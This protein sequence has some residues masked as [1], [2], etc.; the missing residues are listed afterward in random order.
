MSFE[1]AVMQPGD[2]DAA[3]RVLVDAFTRREPLGQAARIAAPD[4]DALLRVL[5][6]K[7]VP[8]QLTIVARNTAGEIV[9]VMLNEDSGTPPPDGLDTLSRS[10]VPIWDFLHELEVEHRAGG[11]EPRPGEW[12]HLFLLAVAEEVCGRGV[13][14][15]M[16][17]KSLENAKGRGY[18]TAVVEATGPASQNIFRKLGFT[19]RVRRPYAGHPIFGTV[20]HAGGTVLM[21]RTLTA[22]PPS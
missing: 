21:E 14:Q 11:R 4:F 16:V 3:P 22:G 15:G 9:G 12:L 10:F 19:D 20:A 1:Y 7:I 13:A 18:S 8:E 2:F 17:A 6:P 5:A